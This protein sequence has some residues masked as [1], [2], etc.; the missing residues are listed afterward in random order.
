MLWVA[1]LLACTSPEAVSCNSAI[2]PNLFSDKASCEQ[3]I[4]EAVATLREQGM[5]AKGGC[6]PVKPTGQLINQVY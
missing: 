1:V 6:N 4:R 2:N 3:N 5:A